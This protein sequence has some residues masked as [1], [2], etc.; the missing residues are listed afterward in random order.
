MFKKIKRAY[1]VLSELEPET[2]KGEKPLGDG[3]AQ[4]FGEPTDEEMKEY[5]RELSGTDAWYK[6]IL[7]L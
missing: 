1:A 3:K 6:R 4:F 5:E 7:K 2:F